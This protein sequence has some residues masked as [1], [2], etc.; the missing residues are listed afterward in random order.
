[1]TDTLR[2]TDFETLLATL[3]EQ[4]ERKV[5]V[6]LP[7]TNLCFKDGNLRVL[8]S[9][10]EPQLTPT[11]TTSPVQVF[12][13]N[14]VFDSGFADRL[15]GPVTAT[16]IRK[17]R[18]EGWTDILDGTLNAMIHGKRVRRSNT[19]SLTVS[20]DA[21]TTG[22]E[23]LVPD[24]TDE[25]LREPQTKSVLLR[26]LKDADGQPVGT[27]RAL[28]SNA[29][30]IIDH[31]DTL[32]AAMQGMRAAGLGAENVTQCDL[33]ARRMYVT[34]E[35][36][37]VRAQAASLLK[38]YV[39]PFTGNRG[40]D[41][42]VVHAGFV[43][44]NS[45]VGD[46]TFFLYPRI[47]AEVCTN[48]MTIKKDVGALVQRHLGARLDDGLVTYSDAT[49]RA[50]RELITRMAEDTVRTF[51]T[52]DYLH[53]VIRKLEERAGEPVA[54]PE[55]AIKEVTRKLEIPALYD[56]VLTHFIKGA[57]LSRGG[58]MHAVTAAAQS[59]DLDADTAFKMEER[60]TAMLLG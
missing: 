31:V 39:S 20:G 56:D 32:R 49:H 26:A 8:R 41:N 1:M 50:N 21:R 27:A 13:P 3:D 58:I 47:V 48:G 35:V 53:S 29:Y 24:G 9:D 51:L 57:D 36:P 60:A 44:G 14:E 33:T 25:W 7:A 45:E 16:F 38:D 34:V 46:G 52:E 43:L 30:K 4:Q 11:G 19:N 17:L 6:I 18:A 2:K 42:P 40:A 37:E 10:L 54:K 22:M 15:G 28:L 55:A 12:A 5:D 59:A 23:Q